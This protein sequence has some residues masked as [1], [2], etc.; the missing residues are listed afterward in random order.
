MDIW[1]RTQRA[2][3]Q[4]DDGHHRYRKGR[5]RQGRD[6]DQKSMNSLYIMADSGARG[7]QAQ[8]RQLAACAA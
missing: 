7:S 3:R 2:H 8:I 5:E 6:H 1:S 4:G